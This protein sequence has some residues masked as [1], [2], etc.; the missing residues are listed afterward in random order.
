MKADMKR[1]AA[2]AIAACSLLL[3]FACSSSSSPAAGDSSDAGA[4]TASCGDAGYACGNPCDPG[5]SKGVGQFCNFS[6]DC[7]N[8]KEAHLCTTLSGDKTQHFCTH[9]CTGVEAG[10]P[11]DECGENAS[12]ACQGGQCGCHPNYCN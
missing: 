9:T 10:A 12:C 11:A 7:L 2:A 8:T 4:D 5:N 1:G 3:A 6:S